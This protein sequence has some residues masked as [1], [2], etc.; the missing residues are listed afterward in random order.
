MVYRAQQV[1]YVSCDVYSHVTLSSFRACH[2]NRIGIAMVCR[3]PY[4]TSCSPSTPRWRSEPKQ[5]FQ[6]RIIL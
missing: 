1:I 4:I 2:P 6:Q 3:T 5:L